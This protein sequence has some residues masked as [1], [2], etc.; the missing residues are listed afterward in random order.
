MVSPLVCAEEWE[1]EEAARREKARLWEMDEEEYDALTEEQKTEF[2]AFIQQVKRERKKRSVSFPWV[3]PQ[4]SVPQGF[5]GSGD[6]GF[7]QRGGR[8]KAKSVYYKQHKDGQFHLPASQGRKELP[9]VRCRELSSVLV[10]PFH[11]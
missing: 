9:R 11:L 4:D 1:Q 5:P 2:D 7:A 6:L 8:S 10:L 3:T